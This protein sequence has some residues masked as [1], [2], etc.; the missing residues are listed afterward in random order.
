[1]KLKI[2]KAC[3]LNLISV[4][5]PHTRRSNIMQQPRSQPSQQSFSQGISSQQNGI[6]SQISQ[7][8]IDDVLADNQRFGSQEKD[9]SVKRLSCLAPISYPWEES[10]MPISRSS[11][12]LTRRWSS[13][14]A[15]ENK[16]QLNDELEHKITMMETSLNRSGMILESVEA[17]IMQVNKGTK[18][19]SLEVE[20]IRQKSIAH[21]DSLHLLN[22]AQEETRAS[23]ESISNQLRTIMQQVKIQEILLTVMSL[24][25]Q[26]NTNYQ[27]QNDEL[28][29]CLSG[30]LQEILCSLK[31]LKPN[32]M[33]LSIL[34]PKVTGASSSSQKPF[35]M[36]Y[37]DQVSLP[38]DCTYFVSDYM[39]G[40]KGHMKH[41]TLFSGLI[42][43]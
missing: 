2:N 32:N 39:Y 1:M 34:P 36:R 21:Q 3:D 24:R 42:A 41:Q 29:K 40:S 12:S 27:K 13:A 11:S 33:P 7:S 15:S 43:R 5:P 9:N 25:E 18:E 6:F 20:S 37:L 22:R 19:L 28:S 8:S 26:I 23:L 38:L 35:I 16:C 14:T 10:Q 17:Y 30:D 4:L 31:T